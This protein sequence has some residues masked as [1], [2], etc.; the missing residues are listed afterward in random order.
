MVNENLVQV[1]RLTGELASKASDFRKDIGLLE[2][3]MV[4]LSDSAQVKYLGK[5]SDTIAEVSAY[6][7]DIGTFVNATEVLAIDKQPPLTVPDL[8]AKTLTEATAILS[9]VG[10]S[11]IR[12]IDRDGGIAGDIARQYP[13]AGEVVARSDEVQLFVYTGL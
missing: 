11:N 7:S 8:S 13:P 4:D 10:F 1:K 2:T 9:G 12:T 6:L 5:I 3:Y